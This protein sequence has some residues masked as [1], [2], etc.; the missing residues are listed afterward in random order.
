MPRIIPQ[1]P[2]FESIEEN[3]FYGLLF[4]RRCGIIRA[5]FGLQDA[6]PLPKIGKRGKH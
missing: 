4:E 5:V 1:T 6:S 3:Y 2:H